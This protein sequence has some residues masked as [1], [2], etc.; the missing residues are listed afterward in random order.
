MPQIR[1]TDQAGSTPVDPARTRPADLRTQAK[2]A[3]SGE[4]A[5]VE[6]QF[7]AI[8]AGIEAVAAWVRTM[9]VS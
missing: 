6:L 2:R 9:Q 5:P 1:A 3:R 7:W 4:T 8:A